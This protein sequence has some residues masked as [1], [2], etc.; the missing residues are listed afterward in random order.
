MAT[1]VGDME[2][3]AVAMIVMA[4]R[5][6]IIIYFGMYLLAGLQQALTPPIAMP[7]DFGKAV[8]CGA[9]RGTIGF[10]PVGGC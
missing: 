1:Q 9:Q 5:L 8:G 4:V 3:M 6:G 7:L 10:T 2:E